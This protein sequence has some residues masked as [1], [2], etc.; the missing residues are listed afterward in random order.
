[1]A[2][3][4]FLAHRL[5][6]PPD[7]GDKVRS[8]NLLR[9]LAQ[10]HRVFLA[11]FVDDP[12]DLRHVETVA[13]QCAGLHASRLVPQRARLASMAG[14]LD[15][16]ALTVHYYR[17]KA[18]QRWVDA[19]LARERIDAALVFSSSMAQY[20]DR[21]AD[22]PMLVDF[23]DVDSAKWA[24]YAGRKRWPMSWIYA[25][26]G[27]TLLAEERRIAARARAGFFATGKEAQLF[28][29]LAPESAARCFAL[30]NG[31]DA[32]FF[33][34]AIQRSSP[35]AP[36]EAAVVFTGAMDYWPNE[37]AVRWFAA[38]VLPQLRARRPDVRFYIVGRNPTSAVCSLAGDGVVVTGTVSDV[39]PYLQHAA[40]VVAP[41]RLARGVQ[42]KVL[43]AMAMQ[44][45]VVAAAEC[46]S[47]LNV[48]VGAEII[49]AE[50]AVEYSREVLGLLDRAAAAEAIG[51]AARRRVLQSYSWEAHLG[52]LDRHLMAH[53]ER[54][55]QSAS[56]PAAAAVAE[57]GA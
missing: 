47:A 3:L 55:R 1:M 42:N 46:V 24:A 50:T 29:S 37:D 34:P 30:D 31:V 45:A 11:T 23:V 49:A 7:K 20:L 10:R 13:G 51:A 39:R 4:L 33:A 18:L 19:T 44:R 22:L 9:H 16:Q 2:T 52:V 8:W 25:R 28:R 26:E 15:G 48:R 14:L 27:R 6:Y 5:P 36:G 17:D 12:A 35:F 57:A 40:V 53:V 21:H 54:S 56:P 32:A 38:E 43:E 41:L